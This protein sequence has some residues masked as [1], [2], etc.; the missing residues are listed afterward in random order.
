MIND[1]V[2]ILNY[3]DFTRCKLLDLSSGSND[4]KAMKKGRITLS[5][6]GN[7]IFCKTE[8]SKQQYARIIAGIEKPEFTEEQLENM[9]IGRDFES[10]LRD[11]YSKDIGM[12]I[13]ELNIC[14]FKQNPIFSASIDGILENGDL[15]E[16]KVTNKQ[17]P[18]FSYDDFSEIPLWYYW[19]MQGYM[20]ILNRPRCH[21][22]SY[23]RLDNKKYVRIVPYNHDRWINEVYIPASLFHRDYVMPILEKEKI[24]TPYET[25][26]SIE[27]KE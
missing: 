22:V 7:L 24:P 16:F 21:Y 17:T 5:T 1:D 27:N 3:I 8:E 10:P 15:V 14:I 13:Y 25:F 4:W 20:F 12:K 19:Q 11:E 2:N 23:S 9:K 26:K 6:I 18:D